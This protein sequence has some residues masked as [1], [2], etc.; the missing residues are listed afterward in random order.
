MKLLRT[1][2]APKDGNTTDQYEDA[3]SINEATST[4]AVADGA[5]AAVYARQWAELL[6]TDF[7]QGEPFPST[8][9]LFWTRVST[10]GSQWQKS[11]GGGAKSWY[12][13]EK[14]P[15]GSQASLLVAQIDLEARRLHAQ[16][17]GDVCCFLV[18]TDTLHYAFP[19]TKSKQFDT[20]PGLVA[21]DPAALKDRPKIIRF[22]VVLPPDA[23]LLIMTD[24]LAA[25]FLAEHE[26]KRKPWNHFPTDAAFLGWLKGTRDSGALKND[27]ITLLDIAT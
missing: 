3:W 23:R 27:D 11:V 8:D 21:T 9:E 7:A 5:S 17:I 24:A 15:Q 10:L 16:A 22:S 18:A 12:A 25:W 1:L 26:R 19:L 20:H 6:V 14:V 2:Q 13:L 4:L